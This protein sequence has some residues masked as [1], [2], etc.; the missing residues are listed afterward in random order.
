MATTPKGQPPDP[1]IAAELEV[2]D[3]RTKLADAFERLAKI[4]DQTDQHDAANHHRHDAAVQVAQAADEVDHISDEMAHPAHDDDHSLN[5]TG[6][7]TASPKS[8]PRKSG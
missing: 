7:R 4:E 2:V 3:A 5:G 8:W 1:H 6:P